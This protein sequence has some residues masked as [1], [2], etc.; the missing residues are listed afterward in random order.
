MEDHNKSC[1]LK[2]AQGEISW[3]VGCY[4][5]NP[6]TQRGQRFFILNMLVLPLIPITF[7]VRHISDKSGY[8]SFKK[9]YWSISR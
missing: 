6:T 7:L 8:D 3:R 9:A 4:Q 5:I 2:V 1:I